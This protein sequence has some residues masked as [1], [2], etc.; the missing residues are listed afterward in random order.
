MTIS[1]LS[2]PTWSHLF[3]QLQMPSG[4]VEIEVW[5]PATSKFI[6]PMQTTPQ[7]FSLVG[8]IV[9]L[10]SLFAFSIHFLKFIF[11]KYS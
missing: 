8:L 7:S 1:L 3:S 11:L 10:T 6:S 2:L 9:F 4:F 5:K